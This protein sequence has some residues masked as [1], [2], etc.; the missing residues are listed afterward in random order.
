MASSI[1]I[2]R[3][4]IAK[5]RPFPGNL[6]DGQPALNTNSVEPGLFF[7]ASDG[8]IVKSG[9]AA[10]TSDGSPPNAGGVGQLGNTIGELWLDKSVN[11]PIL[12][13]YDGTQ[14]VNAGS[15]G[16]GSQ[17]T[18]LRWSTL[19]TAGQT[20]LS[21]ADSSSQQLS[22]TAGLEEVYVN[23]AFLR[24]G[25]DYTATNGSTITVSTPL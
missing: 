3:S 12:K 18:L 10:I 6:L 9:P 20:V 25:V 7:K 8:S 11:P 14:W 17:V 4:S 24:R 13:V 16:G 5:E 19:A 22:Y 15:G 2:L 21:G 23:G 1:Q